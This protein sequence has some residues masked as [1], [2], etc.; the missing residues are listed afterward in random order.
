MKASLARATS[1]GVVAERFPTIRD[2]RKNGCGLKKYRR[3]IADE[4]FLDALSLTRERVGVWVA[5]PLPD[6]PTH[7]RRRRI[8]IRGDFSRPACTLSPT[9]SHK[10]MG[11][12]V[13]AALPIENW[14]RIPP[15]RHN[16]TCS[17]VAFGLSSIEIESRPQRRCVPLVSRSPQS[18]RYAHYVT[19]PR[20]LARHSGPTAIFGLVLAQHLASRCGKARSEL[21]WL[22][23]TVAACYGS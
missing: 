4:H 10:K 16:G 23:V 13:R 18:L 15:E 8:L 3:G 6:T 20:W 1:S 21:R 12:G 9:L 22:K 5:G 19:S 11:E 2:C 14:V 17:T 7:W